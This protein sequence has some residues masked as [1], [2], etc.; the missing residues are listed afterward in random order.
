M[1]CSLIDDIGNGC[2]LST[3]GFTL[4]TTRRQSKSRWTSDNGHLLFESSLGC[5]PKRRL[6]KVSAPTRTTRA[7]FFARRPIL[8]WT[9]SHSISHCP[10]RLR[11]NISR[12]RS[13]R[14]WY[15]TEIRSHHIFLVGSSEP[16]RSA[17]VAS[18][19]LR[20]HRV[21]LWCWRTWNSPTA[22]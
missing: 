2:M 17:T 22:I 4:H 16:A 10:F 7:L 1:K 20:N 15:R 8:R 9:C 11:Q 5:R 19:P 6:I 14:S 13:R 18:N 21:V 3:D 12:A